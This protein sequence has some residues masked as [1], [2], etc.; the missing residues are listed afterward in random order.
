MTNGAASK[1][2]TLFLDDPRTTYRRLRN[3]LAGQA[4]GVT[5]DGTLLH[6]ILKILFCKHLLD[7]S[8][9]RPP[10]NSPTTAIVASYQSAFSEVRGLL[11]RLFSRDQGI[12]LDS[13]S[14]A[15]TH[16]ALSA[17]ALDDPVGDTVGDAFETF[18]GADLRG[19]EGQFF[20]P[21]NAIN[22]LLDLVQL[23]PGELVIDPACG[24]GGFL[25]A[26]VRHKISKG[27]S[28]AQALAS[29]YGQDKDA[30]LV[31]L[32][33]ARLA[34]TSLSEPNVYC[35]DSLS[36]KGADETTA[37][38]L[39]MAGTFDVVLT[40][41]PFGARIIAAS[42]EVQRGFQLGYQ[43]R[44]RDDGASR[45]SVLQPSVPPQ[46]LFVERCVSL[47]KPGGRVGMVVPE[48]LIS[49]R[50]YRYVVSWIR[51]NASIEAVIGM[52]EALFKTSG[53]GGTH[54]KTCL[55]LLRKN[56]QEARPSRSIFMA[57]V[58]WC[59]N[60]S[61]GRRTDR[62]EL[63]EVSARFSKHLHGALYG[64]DHLGYGIT[65]TNVSDDILA[66]RY[67]DP[68][69]TADLMTLKATH[70]LVKF[71]DLVRAD[72]LRVTTGHEVGAKEYGSGTIPF[73]RTSDISNWELKLDPKHGLSEDVYLSY[74]GKQDVREGD[75]LMV[76]D[77]TYLIGT[78]AYV[79]KYDT[80]IVFQSHIYKIRSLQPDYL[81][82][83][84]LLASLSSPPVRRQIRAKRF[85]QD[86][87][88]SLG[89]RINELVLPIPKDLGDRARVEEMVR[90]AI[91]QRVEAREL[92][93]Q[94]CLEV[95]GRSRPCG[96]LVTDPDEEVE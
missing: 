57:E 14:L 63:P 31:E 40:N 36:C 73:V 10:T 41:P 87:I 44:V 4:L 66:P 17:L 38:S 86:I 33:Y 58:R 81:S 19:P 34:F 80:R 88:D 65:L 96:P 61:R 13:E 2:T 27:A 94:A 42:P 20:T 8:G 89:N 12:V 45:T 62:D 92:A 7:A 59:G 68:E 23:Q 25:A 11:P 85:T 50:N 70:D 21:H 56:D 53:K 30:Y 52:P 18:M 43:W 76:R 75:L 77:G 46:V 64:S 48:S 1:Q 35:V 29:V 54:T 55:L 78:C 37:P 15:Y 49:G 91:A 32:A 84:L 24:A 6:E 60:D 22:L 67:Y 39:A 51:Q 71:S 79:T 90:E 3:Y 69:V 95:V 83:F 72:I 9:H 93:R 74:A 47:V 82:P 5:R 16:A 26:S 28:P